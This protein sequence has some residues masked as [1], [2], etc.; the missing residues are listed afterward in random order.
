MKWLLL[1]L[2]AYSASALKVTSRQIS[3]EEKA[4]QYEE[5]GRAC[6]GLNATSCSNLNVCT[7]HASN[8]VAEVKNRTDTRCN[9]GVVPTACFDVAAC[10]KGEPGPTAS[11]RWA[12]IFTHTL[13][14]PLGGIRMENLAPLQKLAK[15]LGNTDLILLVPEWGA[16]RNAP[17]FGSHPVTHNV[18][19][20]VKAKLLQQGVKIQEVPWGTPPGMKY[21]PPPGK[22]W[23]GAQDLMRLHIL[24]M[25]EYAAVAYFDTDTQLTGNGDPTEPLRCAAKNHFIG[26]SG[27]RSPFNIGYFAVKPS[28]ALFDATVHYAQI[29]DF[30]PFTNWGDAGNAPFKGK[31]TGGECGQGFLHALFYKKTELGDKAFALAGATRP[32]AKQV[33]RCL[34]NYQKD[35]ECLKSTGWTCAK[36]VVMIHK[37]DDDGFCKQVKYNV[38]A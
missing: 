7:W 24:K 3:L 21:A 33:D 1:S 16:I 20:E 9:D 17:E 4:R 23:C 29:A 10:A 34:W 11:A 13:Q 15:S 30:D 6:S 35:E 38:T 36:S 8:C 26:T 28:R 2:V 14:K 37:E 19:D 12:F 18:T 25:E 5:A 27:P 31:Y 22:G 32:I